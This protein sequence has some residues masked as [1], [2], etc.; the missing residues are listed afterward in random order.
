IRVITDGHALHAYEREG[1][2]WLP[3]QLWRFRA[4]P[5]GLWGVCV[6]PNT[7]TDSDVRRLAAGIRRVSGCITDVDAALC[8]VRRMTVLD[9]AFAAVFPLALQWRRRMRRA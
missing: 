7:M 2:T 6:H 3:Q 4:M 1:F 8:D 5:W 9:A